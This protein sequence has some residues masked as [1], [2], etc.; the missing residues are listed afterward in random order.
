MVPLRTV[1]IL[2]TALVLIAFLTGYFYW[3]KNNYAC[4]DGKHQYGDWVVV[5]SVGKFELR[6][7]PFGCAATDRYDP[8]TWKHGTEGA[9]AYIPAN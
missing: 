2:A 4:F 8:R 9:P 1:L 3:D 7:K 6:L 5:M